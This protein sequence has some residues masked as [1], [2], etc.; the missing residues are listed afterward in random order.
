MRGRRCSCRPRA[1]KSLMP[2]QIMLYVIKMDTTRVSRASGTCSATRAW[3][4]TVKPATQHTL[5][6]E[7]PRAQP[8]DEYNVSGITYSPAKRGQAQ[9]RAT[10]C[11]HKDMRELEGVYL[12]AKKIVSA[13]VV[14]PGNDTVCAG[15]TKCGRPGR[16]DRTVGGKKVVPGFSYSSTRGI[17]DMCRVRREICCEIGF[18]TCRHRRARLLR[19]ASDLLKSPWTQKGLD[20]RGECKS[21]HRSSACFATF[22]C[23]NKTSDHL[24]KAASAQSLPPREAGHVIEYISAKKELARRL[25]RALDSNI[26]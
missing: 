11:P 4:V 26:T 8:C 7:V 5:H 3:C 21:L 6:N 2:V 1:V 10:S 16:E 12:P 9:P 20:E 15:A 24:Q 19:C 17:G 25:L 23:R 22:L 14:T 18:T 13:A